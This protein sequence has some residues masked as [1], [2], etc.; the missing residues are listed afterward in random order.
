AAGPTMSATSVLP[1]SMP[2]RG[3]ASSSTR[4]RTTTSAT[5][6]NSSVRRQKDCDGAEPQHAA[7]HGLCES[8][9]QSGRGRDEPDVTGRAVQPRRRLQRGSNQ[10]APTF[11]PNG[12]VLMR[13]S[14]AVLSAAVLL[15]PALSAQ[16]PERAGGT[17]V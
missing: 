14:R 15:T 11:H 10:F 1:R 5:S 17:P 9:R 4:I 13:L 3:P 12:G 16:N 2:I 6:R 8:R 7:H